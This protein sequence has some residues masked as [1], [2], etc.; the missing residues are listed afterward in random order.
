[1]IELKQIELRRGGKLLFRDT[2]L[3]VYPGQRLGLV[4][5]NGSGKS[6]LFALIRGQLQPDAGDVMLAGQPVIAHVD[7]ASPSSTD[8]ALKFVQDGDADLRRLQDRIRAAQAD[9]SGSEALHA[10][11]EQ[12]D[13]ID[14]F[15][16]EARGGRLLHGLGFAAADFGR[17]VNEFSGGW[18]MRLSLA[19]ALMCRSDILLLDEPTNHLDLPAIVWLEHWLRAYA[20]TLLIISHDRDFL[21]G[22][23][24]HIAHIERQSLASYRGNYSDFEEARAGQLALQQALHAKQQ[25][26]IRHMQSFVD[27]FRYKASK[28]RQAQS[29]LKMLERMP[30][31]AAAHVDSEFHFE[32]LE[33]ERQPQT[34]LRLEN[35][36]VGYERAV[37]DKV[38]LRIHAGDRIGL[39]GAN[40]AGKSTLIKALLDGSTLLDGEREINPYTRCG[41][42]AQHQLDLLETDCS[43]LWHLRRSSEALREQDLLNH[44]GRFGFDGER[45][46]E[47]V[48]PFSGGEKAR[49][50][51]AMLVL[52]RPNLLLLDE[53]TN[54]LD[55]EMRH[56]LSRALAGF[57]GAVLLIS[58]D[59]HLLRT[60]CDE[61]YVAHAGRVLPFTRELDDYPAWLKAQTEAGEDRAS[62][63]SNNTG[64]TGKE[65]RR[66]QAE[67]RRRL[68]PHRKRV[69]KI[70][71]QIQQLR[72]QI[73]ATEDRLRDE[74]LY[75][76]ASRKDEIAGLMQ[77]QAERKTALERLDQAW[78]E[79]SEDLEEAAA[80]L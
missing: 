51:L 61:L 26:E 5:I 59:R 12:M 58:H 62:P 14:G 55:L 10:L 35:A 74:T 20:G 47:P 80:N 54:H 57:G 9:A 15:T 27:R 6:S 68:Q 53:P 66:A 65:R 46:A 21:D 40:G 16:A 56:A 70:E 78:L 13:A 23:C 50:V 19:R 73:A 39:L 2:T 69:K 1:M 30:R 38:Q 31:I 60:V 36:A 64:G 63:A 22:V 48:G 18:R 75:T 28:A 25:H 29:R 37:L 44:L 67:R 8:S 49:L 34:L 17:P 42:F 3:T 77:Q 33:P 71:R 11:Y 24:T 52:E 41:Y 72:T 79:A 45:A 4:G 43:P 32:F 76:D 7:Q